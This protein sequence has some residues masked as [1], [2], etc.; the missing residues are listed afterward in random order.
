[1]A[2]RGRETDEMS[3]IEMVDGYLIDKKDVSNLKVHH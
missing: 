3:D 2:I 1:M